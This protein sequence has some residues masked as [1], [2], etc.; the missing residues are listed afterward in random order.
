M[1]FQCL[2]RYWAILVLLSQAATQTLNIVA[3]QDDDLLF[4]SPDLINDIAS[5]RSVRTV[6]LTAGDAGNGRDYWI[7]RQA[8]SQA[9]YSKRQ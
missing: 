2:L 1:I 7:S 3:H 4:L 5:G 9:A 6:F 8:G